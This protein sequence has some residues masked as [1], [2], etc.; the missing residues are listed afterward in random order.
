MPAPRRSS[1]S[2]ARS[3]TSSGPRAGQ[4]AEEHRGPGPHRRHRRWVRRREFDLSKARYDRIILLCD[5]DVDGS[6][7]RTLL[8]VLLPPHEAAG[9]GPPRLHRPAPA[10]LHGGGQRRCT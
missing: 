5:A 8:L 1:P 6:H 7:I 4:D 3:S 9:G 2:A 10:V